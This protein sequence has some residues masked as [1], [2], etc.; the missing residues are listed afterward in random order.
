MLKEITVF[1]K[2]MY[3]K[4]ESNYIFGITI[5]LNINTNKGRS[6]IIFINLC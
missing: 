3:K 5:F 2:K 1:I 6:L 4:N